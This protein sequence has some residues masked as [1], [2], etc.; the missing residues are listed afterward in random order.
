M[1]RRY[2]QFRPRTLSSLLF[3]AGLGYACSSGG[4]AEPALPS[5]LQAPVSATDTVTLP[6]SGRQSA[7]GTPSASPTAI[8]PDQARKTSIGDFPYWHHVR[9]GGPTPTP[10]QAVFYHYQMTRGNQI[11]QTN[12]G[13]QPSG[14]IMPSE[15]TSRKQPQAIEEALRLMSVGDSMTILFPNPNPD[16]IIIYEVVMRGIYNR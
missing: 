6:P 7:L 15:E 2:M 11:I 8:P 14:G 9:N 10:G 1:Q 3:L 13:A 4:H 12:F 16:S 5:G